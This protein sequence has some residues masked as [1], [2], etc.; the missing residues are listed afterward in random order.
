M[1]VIVSKM[2]NIRSILTRGALMTQSTCKKTQ[3]TKCKT[4]NN[5]LKKSNAKED[6][7]NKVVGVE[8]YN[9]F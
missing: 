3:L 5:K 1:R 4:R 8:E 7:N 6:I 9:F 2:K